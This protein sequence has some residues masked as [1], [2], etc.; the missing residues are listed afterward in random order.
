MRQQLLLHDD[1]PYTSH[2]SSACVA[3]D[4]PNGGDMLDALTH[5]AVAHVERHSLSS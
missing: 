1:I 2:N 3:V 4:V 5:L